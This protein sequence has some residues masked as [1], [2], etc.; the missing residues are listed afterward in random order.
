MDLEVVKQAVHAALDERNGGLDRETHRTHHEYL[1]KRIE[2]EERREKRRQDL[3]DKI[4]ATVVGGLLLIFL[5]GAMTALYN[6][7]KFVIDLY[8]KSQ[9]GH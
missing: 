3:T 7:G 6:V 4:K 5:G 1:N 8:N 9:T 2:R